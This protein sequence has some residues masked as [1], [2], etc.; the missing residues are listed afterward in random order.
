MIYKT[1]AR[2]IITSFLHPMWG[3]F[4]PDLDFEE[5]LSKGWPSTDGWIYLLYVNDKTP[6]GMFALNELADYIEINAV[7]R[8]EFRGKHALE[9]SREAFKWV[10]DSTDYDV[11]VTKP[12]DR[13]HL[14]HFARTCGMKKTERG[15]EI[16]AS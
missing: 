10:F 9:G 1:D 11:I 16:W 3:E 8:P 14:R 7:F 4:C 15:Y 6:M 2:A 13:P 12:L 5:A